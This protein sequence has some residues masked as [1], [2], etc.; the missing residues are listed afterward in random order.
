MVD[1]GADLSLRTEKEQTAKGKGNR[2]EY[3]EN[4]GQNSG[5]DGRVPTRHAGSTDL[6]K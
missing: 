3:P 2:Q 4:Q 6:I 1:K 5:E